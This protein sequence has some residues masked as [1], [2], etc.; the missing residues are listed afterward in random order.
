MWVSDSYE[1]IVARAQWNLNRGNFEEARQE[2]RRL[3]ERLEK[4]KPAV[5]DRRPELHQLRLMSMNM[6]AE[7]DR[8][9]GDFEEALNLYRRLIEISPETADRWRR[10]MALV[11]IDMGAAEAG[12]DELRAQAVSN[13]SDHRVWLTIGVEAEALGR[14]EEAEENIQRGVRRAATPEDKGEAYLILFDFYREQGRVEDAL[15]A[16]NEAWAVQGQEPAYIFPVYQMMMEADDLERAR[17]YLAEERHPL[18]RGFHQ[19]LLAE[20]EGKPDEALKHWKRVA[21]MDPTQFEEGQDMWAEAAL[22]SDLPPDEVV[23]ALNQG[24]DAGQFTPRGLILQAVAEA[25]RGHVDH[26]AGVLGLAQHLGLRSRPRREKLPAGDWA[27]FDE[28]V[29]DDRAKA[30]LRRFFEPDSSGEGETSKTEAE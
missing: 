5:L 9:H 2:F 29:D 14:A 24:L 21:R 28:L 8:I 1:N 13:P 27:L 25:R 30:E 19:G 18:R 26:A 6:Q 10:D 4:V 12:L 15:A 20:R 7:I 11:R 22:R 17:E 16:W 3:S 23:A